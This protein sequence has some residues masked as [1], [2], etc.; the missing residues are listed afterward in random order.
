LFM[1]HLKLDKDAR[2]IGIILTIVLIMMLTIGV[3][4]W[5]AIPAIIP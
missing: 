2:D 3:V 4:T 1:M 5:A